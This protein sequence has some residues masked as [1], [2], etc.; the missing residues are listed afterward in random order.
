MTK[1]EWL[2]YRVQQEM[3]LEV[4]YSY[5]KESGGTFPFEVFKKEFPAFI[6]GHLHIPFIGSNGPKKIDM[7]NI[8]H[9]VYEFY[10]T[11]YSQ[12]EGSTAS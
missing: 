5:Y 9:K 11:K 10:D 8:I 4:F 6:M 3:P 12:T 1:E 2:K 7:S